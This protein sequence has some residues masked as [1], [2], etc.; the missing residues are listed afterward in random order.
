M[1]AAR[2][3]YRCPFACFE[4]RRSFK[5]PFEAGVLAR[6][7]PHCGASA[8]R[9]F[10]K[11]KPPKKDDLKQWEKVRFLYDNGFWFQSIWHSKSGE[12]RSKLVRYPRNLAEAR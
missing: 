10:E 4:C 11:F 7:C 8:K 1:S 5:R 9:L 2:N 3:Q 6:K 12:T